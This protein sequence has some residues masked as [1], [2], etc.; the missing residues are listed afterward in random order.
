MRVAGLSTCR[1]NNYIVGPSPCKKC[2]ISVFTAKLRILL[3]RLN[4]KNR[5]TRTTLTNNLLIFSR[6]TVVRRL[7]IV[8]LYHYSRPTRRLR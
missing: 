6:N 4:I 7:I 5:P 8:L 3:Y 2:P 1:G